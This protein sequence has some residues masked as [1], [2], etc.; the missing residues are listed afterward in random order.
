MAEN[1]IFPEFS[2]K[3]P[4]WIDKG[5][6]IRCPGKFNKLFLILRQEH[7]PVKGMYMEIACADCAKWARANNAPGTKRFLHYYDATG[8]CVYNKVTTY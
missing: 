6:E 3:E 7:M 4:A 8:K 5:I 1:Q 2:G